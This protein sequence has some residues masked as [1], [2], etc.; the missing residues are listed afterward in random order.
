LPS[1]ILEINN[2]SEKLNKSGNEK[3]ITSKET[4]V[5]KEGGRIIHWRRGA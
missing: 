1:K 3:D 5:V 2:E 4:R